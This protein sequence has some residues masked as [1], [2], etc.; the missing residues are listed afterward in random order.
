MCPVFFFLFFVFFFNDTATTE[1]YTL[2]LHD[3]LPI[4]DLHYLAAD[5]FE[6]P[7]GYVVAIEVNDQIEGLGEHLAHDALGHV[8]A[9][10]QGGIDERVQGFGRAVGVHGAEE[11]AA[12]VHRPTELEGLGPAHLADDDPVGSHRQDELHEVAQTDLPRAVESR[13]THLVVGPVGNGHR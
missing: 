8:L 7:S 1:I 4:C 12:R 9:G 2:S 6:L 11:A 3:A 5:A 10:H 13:R